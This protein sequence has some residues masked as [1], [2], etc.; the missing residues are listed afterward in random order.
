MD[1]ASN[2]VWHIL[3]TLALLV[4]TALI[5]LVAKMIA[6]KFEAIEKSQRVI[7]KTTCQNH[8]LMV[9]SM[10]QLTLELHPQQADL[11]Y[12]AF[13]DVLNGVMTSAN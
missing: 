13:K 6:S 2:D 1:A 12:K 5:G 10:L 4:I 8:A 11:I 3:F 7:V 9:T